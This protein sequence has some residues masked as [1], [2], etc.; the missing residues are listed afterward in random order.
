MQPEVISSEV[1]TSAKILRAVRI[2][3]SNLGKKVNVGDFSRVKHSQLKDYVRI[4]RMN[5]LDHTN[6]GRHTYTGANTVIMH[7]DV[8]AFSSISWGVTIGGGEHDHSRIAQHCFIYNEYDDICPDNVPPPYNRFSCKCVI[9]NDVWIAANV[10]I[11]RGITIGDGAV[12]GANALVSKDIPPYAIVGGVPAR[13][14]KF[15][16]SPEIIT[17]LLKLRWWQWSEQKLR[18]NYELLSEV[19]DLNIL[20]RIAQTGD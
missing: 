14:I 20:E 7:S 13:I 15:R 11:L 10:T 12:I 2:R 19:P 4:D 5:H 8:G 6:L 16:F 18:R 9:G 17:A 1:H 3:N